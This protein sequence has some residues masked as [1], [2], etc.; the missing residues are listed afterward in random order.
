MN[1]SGRKNKE[2]CQV[3]QEIDSNENIQDMRHLLG[4]QALMHRIKQVRTDRDDHCGVK[5]EA[6]PPAQEDKGSEGSKIPMR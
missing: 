4:D 6:D 5:G 2:F 1:S 3:N